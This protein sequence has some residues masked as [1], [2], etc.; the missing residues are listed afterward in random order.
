METS[1]RNDEQACIGDSTYVGVEK[2]VIL[3]KAFPVL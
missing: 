3:V 2:E 1:S